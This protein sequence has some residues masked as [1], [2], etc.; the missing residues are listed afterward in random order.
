ASSVSLRWTASTDDVAVAGYTVYLDGSVVGT[1]VSTQFTISGLT[2]STSHQVAVD[3]FDVAGNHSGR[4]SL[5]AKTAA[6]AP[7]TVREFP[8][9]IP[10]LP[11][12]I[13]AG[14]GGNLWFTMDQAGDVGKI[15]PTG[16]FSLYPVPS[17]G[18]LGGIA[19]GPD[20]NLWFVETTAHKIGRI[21]PAGVIT[22]F[23]LPA[24]SI[25]GAG[26]VA[27]LHDN[28]WF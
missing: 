13:T 5:M 25:G 17:G 20:G 26:I 15:T 11:L 12:D 27:G 2:C 1:T 16:A 18:N 10:A 7:G 23:P 14:P 8:L 19:R 21:T 28:M 6:C 9:P 3:A 24:T 22:E 4:A